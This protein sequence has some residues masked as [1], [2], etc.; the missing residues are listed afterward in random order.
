LTSGALAFAGG[1]QSA[2][3]RK[4]STVGAYPR[5]IRN[6]IP[7]FEMPAY[8]GR[9]SED[10]GPDALDLAERARFA[11]NAPSITDPGLR[12]KGQRLILRWLFVL[13]NRGARIIRRVRGRLFAIRR[14][15]L[16]GIEGQRLAEL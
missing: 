9:S 13:R 3:G 6:E 16:G 12:T 8:R 4:A 1:A 2:E 14:R 11:I 7:R 15:H 10:A 5:S